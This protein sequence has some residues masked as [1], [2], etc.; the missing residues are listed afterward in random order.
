MDATH[1]KTLHD[2]PALAGL[3]SMSEAVRAD[4]SVEQS[5]QRLKR[6][7]YLLKQFSEILVS[8]ITAEP[9]YELKTLFSHHAYIL[10]EQIALIRRRVSEMR[11]PPLGLDKV[12]HPGLE[13]LA[14]EV[15]A[16]PSTAAFLMA[17]YEIALPAVVEAC[18][19]LISEAHPL[20][21]APSIRIA[22][23]MNFE[24]SESIGVGQTAVSCVLQAEQREGLL[25]WSTLL[26]DCLTAAGRLDGSQPGSE[27]LP[28]AIRDEAVSRPQVWRRRPRRRRRVVVI[29]TTTVVVSTKVVLLMMKIGEKK[30]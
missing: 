15:E 6:M 30:E 14:K 25:P 29:I 3:C 20:V 24:L 7:H 11:E 16:A 28:A 12:P 2:L 10:A 22:K 9:I 4:W 8:R 5:V 19:R 17:C 13:L 26:A 27:Q 1:Y 21:D 18:Q 23:L